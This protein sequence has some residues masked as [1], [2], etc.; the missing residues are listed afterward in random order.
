VSAL[1][2]T[3]T[4]ADYELLL[5]DGYLDPEDAFETISVGEVRARLTN[6]LVAKLTYQAWWNGYEV[7]TADAAAAVASIERPSILRRIT[8]LFTSSREL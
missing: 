8:R 2:Y 1:A 7:A 6:W 3:G 5:A 4:A